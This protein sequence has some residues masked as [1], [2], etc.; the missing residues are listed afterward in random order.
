MNRS[1]TASISFFA[2]CLVALPGIAAAAVDYSAYEQPVLPPPPQAAYNGTSYTSLP[3]FHAQQ[4]AAWNA[5]SAIPNYLPVAPLQATP[6]A[7]VQAPSVQ[8]QEPVIASVQAPTYYVPQAQ[9]QPAQ[10]QPAPVQPTTPYQTPQY[11]QAPQAQMPQI[12]QQP[13]QPMPQVQVQAPTV[14]VQAQPVY[15]AP[16]GYPTSGYPQA[17]LSDASTPQVQSYDYAAPTAPS[18]TYAGQY[19][20]AAPTYPVSNYQA[21]N[22]QAQQAIATQSVVSQPYPTTSAYNQ[23]YA[24]N[25]S[26]STGRP[27]ASDASLSAEPKYAQQPH[28]GFYLSLRSGI[29]F[30]ENTTL[31]S[32]F[33]SVENEY[34]TGWLLNT[35]VGYSF[36]P[37]ASWVAPRLEGELG[38]NYASIDDHKVLGTKINDP[39]AFGENT[40]FTFLA[41]GYLDFI[42]P[43]KYIRPYIGG[44]LGG[45]YVSFDRYGVSSTGTLLSD[46]DLAFAYQG[47]AGL[48]IPVYQGVTFD[49]GYRYLGIPGVE[50]LSRDGFKSKTDVNSSSLLLGLRTDI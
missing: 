44:G 48:S 28:Q 13:Q 17:Q 50:L 34:K 1:F 19:Q 14:Q 45:A 18:P 6:A 37:I 46:S 36:N 33:G 27:N 12:Q 10:T 38:V 7:Y 41:N 3:A 8:V 31:N 29:T 43:W 47:S 39:D 11:V 49:V 4:V 25:S 23:N 30:P 2:L 32:S 15:N 21:P 9:I 35:A 24:Q 40:T 5:G 42:T 22:Y 16:S 20:Q 26:Q